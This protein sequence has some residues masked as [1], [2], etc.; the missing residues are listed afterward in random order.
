MMIAFYITSAI[1]ILST[2]L[3]ITRKNALHAL[4]FMIISLL[5]LSIIFYLLGS[6]FIAALEI[7]IYAGAIMV[8]FVFVIMMLN[9][10]RA[11]V[12][13]EKEWLSG[14]IWI[15]P[16]VLAAILLA[17]LIWVI[18]VHEDIP[19]SPAVS[20]PKEVGMKLFGPY[21][22]GVELA[23]MLLIAGIIGAYHLGKKKKVVYHRFMKGGT[24]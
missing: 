10:G 18:A 17:E 12:N 20:T 19:V 7:I 14:K 1:T 24:K 23:A 5:S 2:L 4:L 21:L 22:I 16:A 8:L 13:Q 9:L 11:S 15:G 6:P 3:V